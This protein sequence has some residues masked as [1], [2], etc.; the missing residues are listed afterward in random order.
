ML[1]LY[2]L[3][4]S[5]AEIVWLNYIHPYPQHIVAYG[6]SQTCHGR[7]HV[8]PPS[9]CG[10]SVQLIPHL[11]GQLLLLFVQDLKSS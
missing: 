10:I 7:Y 1:C 2:F 6:C 9:G 4:S 8:Y 11:V 3:H 5:L